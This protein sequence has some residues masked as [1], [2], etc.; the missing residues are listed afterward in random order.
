[1]KRNMVGKSIKMAYF[2]SDSLIFKNFKHFRAWKIGRLLLYIYG[3]EP[4]LPSVQFKPR[5]FL[6]L[7][8]RVYNSAQ[9]SSLAEIKQ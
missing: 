1:M 7:S 8:K 4:G 9:G 5:L 3:F 2:F 6:N